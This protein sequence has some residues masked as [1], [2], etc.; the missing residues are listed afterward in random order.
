LRTMLRLA[1]G[2]TAPPSAAIMDSCTLQ[3]T[4]KCG[5]RA[6]YKAEKRRRGCKVHMTVDTLAHLLALQ[7]TATYAQ[8]REQVERWAAWVPEGT[9]DAVEVAFVD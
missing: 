2:R 1:E 3:S 5:P 7:V 9:G 6:G 4:P 8:E